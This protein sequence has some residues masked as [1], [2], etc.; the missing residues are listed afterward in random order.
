MSLTK[1]KLLTLIYIIKEIITF[2]RL[3][4]DITYKLNLI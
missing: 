1:A 2:K 3:I 4:T